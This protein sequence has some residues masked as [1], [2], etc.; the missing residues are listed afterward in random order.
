LIFRWHGEGKP[1]WK[2]SEKKMVQDG[3]TPDQMK[4]W[5]EQQKGKKAHMVV[6]LPKEQKTTE[7]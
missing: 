2:L 4:K 3:V 1:T 7:E 5:K 6:R